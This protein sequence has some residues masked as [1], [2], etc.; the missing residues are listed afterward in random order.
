MKTR[1]ILFILTLALC[2]AAKLRAQWQV[3]DPQ[4]PD[5]LNF[6]SWG[7]S[8]VDENTVW[9]IPIHNGSKPKSNHRYFYKTTDG[10]QSWTLGE[11]GEAIADDWWSFND[12]YA[13][14]A[15]TAWCVRT[16][17]EDVNQGG[18]DS[19]E[20]LKTV[21]GGD[22]WVRQNLPYSLPTALCGVHFFNKNEG[23]VW[24]EA[25]VN[26]NGPYNYPD[27]W[28][29][30][31]F[32]TQDGGSTWYPAA[33]PASASEG[34]I[35]ASA[36]VGSST[37]D[38]AGDR[39][40][41]GTSKSRVFY[42]YDRGKTW[43]ASTPL[44]PGR[45]IDLMAFRDTLNGMAFSS[46]DLQFNATAPKLAFHTADGGKTWTPLPAT[47]TT[48][49]GWLTDVEYV[50]GSGGVY[51]GV[52][53]TNT[54]LS[55]DNGNTWVR[56]D[57]PFLLW[58]AEFL[59]PNVGWGGGAVHPTPP[60]S[61]LLMYKW[62]GD[63][64][65]R[66][67]RLNATKT[68]SGAGIEG[69]FN[70]SAGAARFANPKGMAIDNSGNVYVADDYNHCIRKISLNGQVST[71]AG[72]GVAGYTNGPGASA[73]FNRPQDVALDANGNL[74][75]ADANN[76]VVRKITPD[77]VV[78]LWAG[79]PGTSGETNGAPLDATFGWP[80]ALAIDG[81]GNLYVSG[82]NTLRKISPAG[83]VSTLHTAP[84]LIW[85]LDADRY[86]NVYFG[87][88]GAQSVGKIAPDGQ[89]SILA[90]GGTGCLDGVAATAS[91]GSVEDLDADDAGNVYVADGRNARIRKIDPEGNVTTLVGSDCLNGYGLDQQPVDG[92]AHLAQLG[93]VRGI[94]LKPSEAL[95]VTA[96][97]DDMVREIRLG[98][99]PVLKGTVEAFGSSPHYNIVPL[100]Q[101][102]PVE[103]ISTM[104]N[105][106]ESSLQNVRMNAAATRDGAP[107]WQKTTPFQHIAA[108][109]Q[110]G[111]EITEALTFSAPGV[112]QVQL[113]CFNV[114]T[115]VFG[116]WNEEI[117]VSDSILAADDGV[118][119][120]YESIEQSVPDGV[121]SYGQAFDLPVADT[122]TGFSMK[123]LLNNVSFYFSVYAMDGGLP[124]QLLFTSD[125]ALGIS[126]GGPSFYYHRLPHSL[127][128]PAGQ[129]LF[130]VT[131][132]EP[133]G[134]L[135]IGIDTDRNDQSAWYLSADDNVEQWTPA[136]EFWGEQTGPVYML[137]PVFG[138]P[139]MAVSDAE[140]LTQSPLKVQIAPNPVSDRLYV[141]VQA[142]LSRQFALRLTDVCGKTVIETTVSG[143]TDTPVDVS[144]LP[145]GVYWVR[146]MN[147]QGEAVV[148]VVK[149]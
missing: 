15:N 24:G 70:G 72:T 57:T 27:Y 87:I 117:I 79:R 86:G 52:S 68:I 62:V 46:V 138:T 91:F 146:V 97:D 2:P 35:F 130:A 129:Y 44:Q 109:G 22:V 122:L 107:Y 3:I 124:G 119:Y 14:D 7:I 120:Y 92:P 40:W 135:H 77:G 89:L 108:G 105:F 38:V 110:A 84:G 114:P 25:R 112:Y 140:E 115:N 16:N 134:T 132:W 39:I 113:K 41:F 11:I 93:R 36:K 90:G 51:W 53:Q 18:Q 144:G 94:L 55:K 43:Q 4:F 147:G 50:P 103:F 82:T 12:I 9:G 28:K 71:F 10:G 100:A 118:A 131:Q 17:L 33:T 81:N 104:T 47:S 23:A 19:S 123:V 58:F 121:A 65:L 88:L 137:R 5:S 142:T 145:A 61:K 96:W 101:T 78:T 76:Y 59:S 34:I 63:S 69:Y 20:V 128:L 66:D 80:A 83:Q 6:I 13:L 141:K 30:V 106:G 26:H 111:F 49:G 32:Y 148:K 56:E 133:A 37:H 1:I 143:D 64:L 21:D 42:T 60:T 149:G 29:I 45:P 139:A 48:W 75:V 127:A 73:Q 99:Q 116:V 136:F 102:Q 74:Y 98:A 8:V 67:E 85:A 54:V 31:C 126:N 95:L 125:T